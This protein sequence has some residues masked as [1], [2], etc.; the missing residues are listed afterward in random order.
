MGS[1][2]KSPT[3]TR[4]KILGCWVA[5]FGL[6][7]TKTHPKSLFEAPS[8]GGETRGPVRVVVRYNNFPLSEN[9]KGTVFSA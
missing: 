5:K 7:E 1:E 2:V 3:K 4:Y 8:G 6:E 9:L